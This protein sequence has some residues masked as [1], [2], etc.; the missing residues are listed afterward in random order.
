MTWM[1]LLAAF[2]LRIVTL[3]AAPLWYDEQFTVL[4]SRMDYA[5]MLAAVA[6]DAHPPAFFVLSWVWG[7]V[8]GTGEIAM[9]LWPAIFGAASVAAAD[10]VLRRWEVSPAARLAAL[11]WLGFSGWQIAMSQEARMYTMLQLLYLLAVLAAV[12]GHPAAFAA[13]GAGLLM[14]HAWG[15]LYL[16][17]AGGYYLLLERRRDPYAPV[18]AGGLGVGAFALAWGRTF[19]GQMHNYS[20]GAY[21]WVAPLSSGTFARAVWQMLVGSGPQAG[22]CLALLLLGGSTI[23]LYHTRPAWALPAVL[24]GWG[25]LLGGVAVSIVGGQ[26]VIIPRALLP[27]GLYIVLPVAAWLAAPERTVLRRGAAALAGLGTLAVLLGLPA[28]KAE[29]GA[30]LLP[31]LDEHTG[32]VVA[33]S[34]D[35]WTLVAAYR[36]ERT[37]YR[38]DIPGCDHPGALPPAARSTLGMRTIAPGAIPPN[39]LI[40]AVSGPLTADC[41]LETL[42]GLAGD[43]ISRIGGNVVIRSTPEPFEIALYEV[44]HD[45]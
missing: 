30:A 7:R 9:R 5:H 11:T 18:L 36:P 22:I 40:L 13:A 1:L 45:R 4:V 25:P 38:L 23:W 26:S 12:S 43:V 27:S 37:L 31:A 34:D 24:L 44:Q 14:T 41:E 21:H 28:A 16:A 39:A 6:A 2:L 15:W 29:R 35:T 42:R 8:A 19:A 10:A 3:G 17:A 33:A 32:P 20:A